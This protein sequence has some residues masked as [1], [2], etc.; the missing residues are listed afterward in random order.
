MA[1]LLPTES[2]TG[3]GGVALQQEIAAV[4]QS[5]HGVRR[6]AQPRC[7]PAPLVSRVLFCKA[8]R[9]A[10]CRTPLADQRVAGERIGPGEVDAAAA[11]LGERARPA[12]HAAVR[13]AGLLLPTIKAHRKRGNVGGQADVAAAAE[14]TQA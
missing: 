12:H 9:V 11:D 10:N 4:G 8:P 7:L 1:L 2:V 13:R 14:S 5:A 6:P 3:C